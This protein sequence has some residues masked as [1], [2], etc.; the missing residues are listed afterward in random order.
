MVERDVPKFINDAFVRVIDA[1]RRD[2]LPTV[3][4]E[5]NRAM[6]ANTLAHYPRYRL[7]LFGQIG[8]ILDL[9]EHSPLKSEGQL[10]D[11]YV[12]MTVIRGEHAAREHIREGGRRVAKS[13]E[14]F[15]YLCGLFRQIELMH[16]EQLH[17]E[18][19]IGQNDTVGAKRILDT[20]DWRSKLRVTANTLGCRELIEG[21]IARGDLAQAEKLLQGQQEAADRLAQAKKLRDEQLATAEVLKRRWETMSPEKRHP[22]GKSKL[23]AVFASVGRK[24]RDFRIATHA[25]EQLL[26]KS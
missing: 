2:G 11:L 13:V 5:A 25:F 9:L 23:E 14:T 17:W 20:A 21:P 1:S 26:P 8:R 18:R 16:D 19:A 24:P 12:I 10:S 22:D 3:D 15:T 6:V 4:M 7:N